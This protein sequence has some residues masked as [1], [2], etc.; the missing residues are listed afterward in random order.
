LLVLIKR[1][2]AGKVSAIRER[3]PTGAERLEGRHRSPRRRAQP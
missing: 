3:S 2:Q 1:T